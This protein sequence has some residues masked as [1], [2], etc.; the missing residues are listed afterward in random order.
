MDT[1][2]AVKEAIRYINLIS[3]D[4]CDPSTLYIDSYDAD[5]LKRMVSIRL[6][7]HI[8]PRLQTQI[9][10]QLKRML[11]SKDVLVGRVTFTPRQL[12]FVLYLKRLYQ[13]AWTPKSC[14]ESHEES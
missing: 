9:R 4:G 3:F 13:P 2:E 14:K 8:E 11:K 6:T 5:P 7:H 1:H 12:T 10:K